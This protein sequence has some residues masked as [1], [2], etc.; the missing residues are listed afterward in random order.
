MGSSLCTDF[1]TK[2]DH[3]VERI[4]HLIGL[5]PDERLDWVPPGTN[6]FTFAVLLGHV[7]DCLAGFA[8]TLYAANP[9]ELAHL[10][11]LRQYAG[12]HALSRLAASEILK[13]FR[14]SLAQGFTHL[15]DSDFVK[16]IPTVFVP[17]GESLLTLLLINFEH[18]ASHK[19]QL[20]I[21]LRLAGVAVSSRDLYH[22]SGQ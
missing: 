19:F 7:M 3:Q 20:F 18:L 11:E 2:L 5:V 10:L 1:Q 16:M 12:N 15:D 13:V 6:G 9:V 8:A 17:Q 21:W 14:A 22:F 4:D